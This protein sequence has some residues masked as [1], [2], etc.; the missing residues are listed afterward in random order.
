MD[1]F[2]KWLTISG[3]VRRKCTGSPN[4]KKNTGCRWLRLQYF[5]VSDRLIGFVS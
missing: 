2:E 4:K 1:E 5:Y 3:L